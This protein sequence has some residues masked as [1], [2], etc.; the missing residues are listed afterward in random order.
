MAPED[1]FCVG[2]RI[3]RPR[4]ALIEHGS[5]SVHVKPK[6]MAVLLRLAAADGEVV[7][8]NDLFDA[9]WPGS[10]VS[11]DVLTHSIVELRKA[12]ADSARDPKFIE[13]IPKVG[14]RLIAPVS[15]LQRASGR[16]EKASAKR[17]LP[18]AAVAAVAFALVAVVLMLRVDSPGDNS[19]PR[20]STESPPSV[21]VLPF[22]DLSAAK[23]QEFFA[24]GLTEELINRLTQIRGLQVTGRTSSF[25]FKG[26]NDDIQTIGRKLSVDHVLEGS[27]RRSGERMR[28]TAQLINVDD[29]FHVWSQTFD[30]SAADIFEIQDA[31]SESVARALSIRL[32]VGEIG[33]LEGGTTNVEAFEEIAKGNADYHNFDANSVVRTIDHYQRAIELDPNFGLAWERLANAY[34][35]AWLVF[36]RDE[37]DE[38]ATLAD[39]AIEKALQIA[40]TAPEVL[41]TAAYMHV[42]RQQWVAARKLLERVSELKSSKFVNAT[43]VYSDLLTKTGFATDAAALKERSR[44]ID[45][46][47]SGDALYLAHQYA[48]LG[49]IEDALDEVARGWALGGYRPQLSMEGLVISLSAGD[50]NVLRQW[51]QHAIEYTQPGARGIHEAM[52]DSLGDRE[53]ALQVLR[54]AYDTSTSTDYFVIVWAGYYGDTDLALAAMQRSPDLWAIW[55]P[56]VA[57]ARRKP[58]FIEIIHATGLPE[59]WQEFGWGDFC[60]PRGDTGIVCH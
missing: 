15:E 19:Q 31:I 1:D 10:V 4:R 8:R 45:P 28:I 51:L 34:R 17:R 50:E 57:D 20:N 23:D 49:R 39:A 3:V 27:I 18:V 41:T 53:R 33:T 16:G 60:R 6:S 59:Y 46:L 13:T 12:F 11:D 52:L 29:G 43:M 38:W 5:N 21:V 35:N 47:H 55:L 42:D 56:V 7:T 25:Y 40:P 37:Y 44:I 22:V 48:M 30:R 32:S 9:V 58:E 36:G 54:E 26:R 2:D 14:F 24:D